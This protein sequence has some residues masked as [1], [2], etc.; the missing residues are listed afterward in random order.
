MPSLRAFCKKVL[1]LHFHAKVVRVIN[2]NMSE[3]PKKTHS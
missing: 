2:D 3:D 1:I